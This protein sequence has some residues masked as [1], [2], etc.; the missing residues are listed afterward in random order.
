VIVDI[1]QFKGFNARYGPDA[2]DLDALFPC[3]GQALYRAKKAR[4]NRV[5][6][7]VTV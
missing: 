7:W 6:P 1:D 3:A 4:R 5:E 2:S